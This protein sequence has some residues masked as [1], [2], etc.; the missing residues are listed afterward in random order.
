M[1]VLTQRVRDR[2]SL[3][4]QKRLE[5]ATYDETIRFN[6]V[7]ID[8]DVCVAQPYLPGTRGVDSPTFLI[9]RRWAAA[10][11]YPIFE[12][13]FYSLWERRQPI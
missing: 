5:I 3:E 4:A 10:G 2:L 1:N 12:Q 7:L 6:I 8:D 11:L 13:V 9:H